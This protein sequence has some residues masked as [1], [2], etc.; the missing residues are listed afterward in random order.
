VVQ[1]LRLHT[2][3][4]EGNHSIPGVAGGDP[5]WLM[6]RKRKE[7]NLSSFISEESIEK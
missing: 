2:S 5:T 6:A 7:K 3:N 4:A 1:W